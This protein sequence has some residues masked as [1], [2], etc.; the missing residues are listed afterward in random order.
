[1]HLEDE[2][3]HNKHLEDGSCGKFEAVKVLNSKYA[4]IKYYKDL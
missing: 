4:I 2:S 3:K 1:M